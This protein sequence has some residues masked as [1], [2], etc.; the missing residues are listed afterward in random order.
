[1]FQA[2]HTL[3]VAP[4]QGQL[5]ATCACGRWLQPYSAGCADGIKGTFARIDAEYA[6][7]LAASGQP[8][9]V[10]VSDCSDEPSP[11]ACM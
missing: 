8:P 6:Q 3:R 10:V 7:H 11:T 1:M 2:N 4:V 9:A 5:V